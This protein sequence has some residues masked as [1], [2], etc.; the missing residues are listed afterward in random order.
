MNRHL[1]RPLVILAILIAASPVAAQVP[2]TSDAPAAIYPR[3]SVATW[4]QVDPSWPQVP[5]GMPSGHVPG[6]AVG[7]DG[8]VY[9]A[10]RANPPI[11][12]FRPDGTFVRSFGT[13]A[14]NMVHHLKFDPEGHLW[15]A[16]VGDQTLKRFDPDGTVDETLGTAGEK[17]LDEEHFNMPSDIVVAETG[18]RFVADGYG[19]G[20]VVHIDKDGTF[21]KA[22][23]EIGVAPGQFSAAHAI[24]LDSEGRLYVADRNNARVQIFDQQGT[25]LDSWDNVVIPWGL[26]VTPEDEIWVCGSSPM[27]WRLS[28][29]MLGC[30]P[31]D[32]VFMKFAPNGRLLQQ[33]T[34][35]LGT[36]GVEAP[37]ECNWVHC[38]TADAEGN[39]YVGDI[40]G[41]R[42]QKFVPMTGGE[43]S[44]ALAAQPEG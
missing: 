5:E 10:V 23:G 26:W 22:W 12:V 43:L 21:V 3:V 38:I 36:T 8:N 15:A 13:G 6:I 44:G 28:D 7:P 31:Q 17:G 24:A 33:W 9:V 19:N 34:V 32:Q 42:A 1:S 30:P 27:P 18:D 25:L 39:L 35:P 2:P 20:R 16:D 41:M 4:Y 37:G 14:L 29:A 40:H 11:R